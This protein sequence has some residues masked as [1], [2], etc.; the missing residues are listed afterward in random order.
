MLSQSRISVSVALFVNILR[1]IDTAIRIK[2]GL[3]SSYVLSTMFCLFLLYVGVDFVGN[4]ALPLGCS[5]W[6]TPL[7]S[8]M[9]KE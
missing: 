8:Y 9:Y 5:E 3:N 7:P 1:V 2:S 4:K 6:Y